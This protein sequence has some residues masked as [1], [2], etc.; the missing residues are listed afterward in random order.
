[1][2][3]R[4][5]TGAQAAT[6]VVATTIGV[7]IPVTAGGGAASGVHYLTTPVQPATVSDTIS[8]TGT[9]AARATLDLAFGATN[10]PVTA[11]RVHVGQQ[12]R[13]GQLLATVDDSAAQAQL[14]AAQAAVTEA[15]TAATATSPTTASAAP[16]GTPPGA[17]TSGGSTT[18]CHTT[19][20]TVSSPSPSP[21][22]SPTP[23][24]STSPSP[25]PTATAS[26][27]P[28]ASPSSTAATA[29]PTRPVRPA[30]LASSAS[31][32]GT[33]RTTRTCTTTKHGATP[34]GGAASAPSSHA[35]G[36]ASGAGNSLSN[37]EQQL[38]TA[39]AGLSATQLE[40]PQAGVVTT[41]NAAVGTLP[42]TPAV[43]LRTTGMN[44]QVPVQEQDAPHVRTGQTVTITFA[45][46]GVTGS[47][48]V[49]AGALEPA[50][51]SSTSGA[52]ALVGGA[53][54]AV[55]SYPVTVTIANAPPGLLPGMS[56]T[57]SWVATSR[58]DV[59][60][61]PTSALQG[62]DA[63]TVVRVLVDGQPRTIPVG[64]GLS[65]SSLT[66]ITS[67][68]RAGEQVITGTST[69]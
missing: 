31:G 65:T 14:A 29:G 10:Q 63:G 49:S 39:Q 54:E 58:K 41:V 5:A 6:L 24:A 47:G 23:T 44:V 16:S 37:A 48:T 36:N 66:Q 28:T 18:V 25:V 30:S 55:V 1:M 61:V 13:A 17:T 64:I 26:T 43:E 59:L 62:S 40:A 8:A 7:L 27:A 12:V 9:V 22:A 15:S 52:A 45:A 38:A 53:T 33:P 50:A 46:L 32:S 67:G 19:T 56:A 69:S 57:V 68:L 4:S 60:S 35:N 20:V 51:S 34:G 21:T 42:G 11:V 3:L 2:R